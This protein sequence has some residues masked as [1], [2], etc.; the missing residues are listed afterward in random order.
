V[1]NVGDVKGRRGMRGDKKERANSNPARVRSDEDYKEDERET[2]HSAAAE[3]PSTAKGRKGGLRQRK[4]RKRADSN[5]GPDARGARSGSTTAS[6][7]V[8][9]IKQAA[10]DVMNSTQSH[11]EL[12]R[13][14]S[15]EGSEEFQAPASDDGYLEVVG[16]RSSLHMAMLQLGVARSARLAQ[17]KSVRVVC[18]QP[19]PL[20]IDGEPLDMEKPGS[21]TITHRNTAL[22]LRKSET[23]QHDALREVF[24]ALEIAESSEVI[25]KSQ[26]TFILSEI[27]NQRQQSKRS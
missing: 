18:K 12:K 20:Q 16:V 4:A 8:D 6:G 13:Q 11:S 2:P 17:G 21:I 7:L 5:T 9:S 23:Q 22:M 19:V 27:A 3:P 15:P 24:H 25:S 26:K 1:S 10:R 14:R